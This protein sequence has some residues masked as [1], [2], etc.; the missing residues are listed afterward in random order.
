MD[1]KYI[2][3]EDIYDSYKDIIPQDDS[4][5]V[6]IKDEDDDK[7]ETFADKIN[8]LT[9]DEEEAIEGYDKILL[10]LTDKKYANIKKQLEIIRDE[11]VAHKEFLE[12]A[13]TDLNAVY[14]DPNDSKDKTSDTL[15]ENLNKGQKSFLSMIKE[16]IDEHDIDDL[17]NWFDIDDIDDFIYQMY[18]N[19][20]D[21]NDIDIPYSVYKKYCEDPD[22]IETWEDEEIFDEYIKSDELK[23]KVKKLLTNKINSLNIAQAK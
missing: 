17:Q 13:L 22:N 21:A 8:F 2:N 18:F 16:Y 7:L 12:Q 4:E 14:I 1:D 9:A 20:L 23:E 6:M 11:E 15:T 5:E 3:L 19:E 10:T